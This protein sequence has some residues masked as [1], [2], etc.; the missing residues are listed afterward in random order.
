[1][2]GVRIPVIQLEGVSMY[3]TAHSYLPLS[4][5]SI[6]ENNG[7]SDKQKVRRIKSTC[8]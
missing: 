6:G 1:M 8:H 2:D 7:S 4:R 3:Y 5:I